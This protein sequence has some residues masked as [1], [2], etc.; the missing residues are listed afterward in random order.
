MIEVFVRFQLFHRDWLR[1][2]QAC[3]VLAGGGIGKIIVGIY[4]FLV[5]LCFVFLLIHNIFLS[6]RI[7]RL[8]F[9]SIVC[10]K[11]EIYTV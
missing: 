1:G 7:R 6:A 11:R 4:D 5:C 8:R 9:V 10:R 3:A 2:D